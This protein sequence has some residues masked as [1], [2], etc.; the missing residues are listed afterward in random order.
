M[1]N[2]KIWEMSF[3]NLYVITVVARAISLKLANPGL[4]REDTAQPAVKDYFHS[5]I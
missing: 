2:K 4:N 5:F 3:N 1:S